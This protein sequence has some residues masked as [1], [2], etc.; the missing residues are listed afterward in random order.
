MALSYY[1]TQVTKI[2][3]RS[4]LPKDAESNPHH[5]LKNGNKNHIVGFKNPYPSYVAP[6]VWQYIAK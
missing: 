4:N 3:E 6:D 1:S 5:V 2:Q